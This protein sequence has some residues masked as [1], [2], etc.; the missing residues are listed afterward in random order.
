MGGWR[1]TT[2]REPHYGTNTKYFT[3]IGWPLI[4]KNVSVSATVIL[5]LFRGQS[6]YKF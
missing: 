6:D 5:S 2:R 1:W 4:S 3:L